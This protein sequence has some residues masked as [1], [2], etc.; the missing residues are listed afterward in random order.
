MTLSFGE[1]P[2]LRASHLIISHHIFLKNPSILNE[3]KSTSMTRR[4]PKYLHATKSDVICIHMSTYMRRRKNGRDQDLSTLFFSIYD[5]EN[6]LRAGLFPPTFSQLP[7][8]G[9]PLASDPKV[10]QGEIAY[11]FPLWWPR[12]E[13]PKWEKTDLLAP[14]SHPHKFSPRIS[15]FLSLREQEWSS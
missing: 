2:S 8:K 9:N 6:F 1:I 5:K 10:W 3:I 15:A 4:S 7:T 11:Q 14:Y 13:I 12:R